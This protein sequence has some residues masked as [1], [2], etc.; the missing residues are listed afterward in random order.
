MSISWLRSPVR[1]C[2]NAQF[3]KIGLFIDVGEMENSQWVEGPKEV[4]IARQYNRII[5]RPPHL[6]AKLKES[7]R[8]WAMHSNKRQSNLV[9][10][11]T[12]GCPFLKRK[13]S[14][15]N[16]WNFY[17]LSLMNQPRKKRR[18]DTNHKERAHLWPE[19]FHSVCTPIYRGPSS[20]W[21][22]ASK[23]I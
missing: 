13:P 23:V 20:Y 6:V 17:M 5:V 8:H 4:S 22:K 14:F 16:R 2:Y 18:V 7:P 19:Y 10:N 11:L 12:K 3:R 1:W 15:A 9:G 21:L